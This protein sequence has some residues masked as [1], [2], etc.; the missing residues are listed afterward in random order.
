M[1]PETAMRREVFQAQRG[2]EYPTVLTNK[3]TQ[4]HIHHCHKDISLL[5]LLITG[6]P[7]HRHTDAAKGSHQGD[8]TAPA[9][10]VLLLP[11]FVVL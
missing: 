10:S 9:K 5:L 6:C 2:L 11:L 4:N 1:A 7:A 8:G 3:Y